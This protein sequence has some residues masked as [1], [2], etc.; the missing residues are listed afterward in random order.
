MWDKVCYALE[1]ETGLKFDYHDM[2]SLV[3]RTAVQLSS[4]GLNLENGQWY[5]R[6]LTEGE[7]YDLRFVTRLAVL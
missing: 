4:V 2:S 7:S 1:H 5:I 3:H 6:G